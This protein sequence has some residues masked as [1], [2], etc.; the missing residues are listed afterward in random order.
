MM[1]WTWNLLLETRKWRNTRKDVTNERQF[2]FHST[3]ALTS[4]VLFESFPSR[5]QGWNQ[6]IPSNTALFPFI[7]TTAVYIRLSLY[8]SIPSPSKKC[9]YPR[10]KRTEWK[11]Q[12]ENGFCESWNKKVVLKEDVF[13]KS[14]PSLFHL[15]LE[16]CTRTSLM[17]GESL[18]NKCPRKTIFS[19]SSSSFSPSFSFP[20][21][22]SYHR[23]FSLMVYMKSVITTTMYTA[24][25]TKSSKRR[26]WGVKE[27]VVSVS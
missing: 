9:C 23:S 27:F 5:F 12:E 21:L 20:R 6:A 25:Q 22:F 1:I 24:Q 3:A 17:K 10:D 4:L 8:F 26:G 18:L 2:A 19:L 14:L 15:Q 11:C 13:E 7:H 16:S